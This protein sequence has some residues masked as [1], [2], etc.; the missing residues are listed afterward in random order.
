MS[1]LASLRTRQSAGKQFKSTGK[2]LHVRVRDS[3]QQ[4]HLL[5][6]LVTHSEAKTLRGDISIENKSSR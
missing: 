5:S 6:V 1:L 3:F 2:K 4:R